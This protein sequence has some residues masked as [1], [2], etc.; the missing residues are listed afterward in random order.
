MMKSVE[1]TP[2]NLLGLHWLIRLRWIAVLG[3]VLVSLGVYLFLDI[4]LPIWILAGCIGFTAVSNAWMAVYR[5]H[6]GVAGP[7]LKPLII[8]ADISVLT[9]LLYFTG[10]AHNPFT[11]LYLLH[12]T[13]AVILL[14]TWGAWGAVVL[15]TG[16]FWLLFYSPHVLESST[17]E[18]CCSDMTMH[19]QGMVVGM[20]LTGCGIAYF[21]ERLT[22]GLRESRQMIA[23]A[24]ADGEKAR[25]TME[26]AT[27]AAGIA[28]E[29]ATPLGTIAVVSQDLEAMARESS[30]DID[31]AADARMIRQEVERCRVII[32]KLGQAG[33]AAEEDSKPLDWENLESLLSGYLSEPV[34]SRLEMRLRR[35]PRR[36][37]FPQSRLF[38]CLSILI[39]NAVEASPSGTPVI[40][41]AEVSGDTCI[42][43]VMDRGAGFQDGFE[44][45]IGEPL[46]TTKSKTGGLGLG[47]YLVKVFVTDL[48][49]ELSLCSGPE[50]E[51][52]LEIKLPVVE[53]EA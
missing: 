44:S 48:G 46:V 49:G 53:T 16:G 18:T 51:T 23:L 3:Q 8:A 32:E 43:R 19:L 45:R 6:E 25:R 38:Q 1:M 9:I 36:P 37:M 34:R 4:R 13:M 27:L 15:C 33:Q 24:R 14:P 35:S 50:G 20:V 12:M 31:F 28:H 2:E 21:V 26:V 7:W 42:F 22:A 39:K 29:L 30:S 47:L 41:T 52:V 10:G 5:K 40:L 11:M 17:G